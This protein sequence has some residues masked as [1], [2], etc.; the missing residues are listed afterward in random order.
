MA[1]VSSPR[2]RPARAAEGPAAFGSQ[3]TLVTRVSKVASP[4]ARSASSS[5]DSS[6]SRSP[7]VARCVGSA[8]AN[9]VFSGAGP[10][11]AERVRGTADHQQVQ[12]DRQAVGRS[13]H[14][15]QAGI[16]ALDLQPARYRT[17]DLLGVAEHRLEHDQGSHD[18]N[19]ARCDC[20]RQGLRSS[21]L[22]PLVPPRL[23]MVELAGLVPVVVG[24]ALG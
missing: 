7:V 12:V 23:G 11:H 21:R 17:G 19:L 13:V 9:G 10:A 8:L 5:T 6:H 18:S 15:D 20:R 3:R 22:R 1:T 14:L 2:R 4:G 24:V 16:D